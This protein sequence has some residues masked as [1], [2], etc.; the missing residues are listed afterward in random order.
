MGRDRGPRGCR[1]GGHTDSKRQRGIPLPR[2]FL[3]RPN[4]HIPHRT[5]HSQNPYHREFSGYG[6]SEASSAAMSYT[7]LADCS[8]NACRGP[9][10]CVWFF[11]VPQESPGWVVR[12]ASRC[13]RIT[14]RRL[15]S[16]GEW[17]GDR[18]LTT[19]FCAHQD[20]L[21]SCGQWL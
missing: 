19:F 7:D 5:H 6:G 2:D 4:P 11:A 21:D 18:P 12:L 9:E 3:Y 17:K 13:R 15:L 14:A 10:M 1:F 8:R 16:R 20:A